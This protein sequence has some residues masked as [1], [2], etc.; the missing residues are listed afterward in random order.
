MKFVSLFVLCLAT[1]LLNNPSWGQ[2]GLEGQEHDSC[3]YQRDFCRLKCLPKSCIQDGINC[4]EGRQACVKYCAEQFL[5][6]DCKSDS[7]SIQKPGRCKKMVSNY[8]PGGKMDQNNL[9]ATCSSESDCLNLINDLILL[10]GASPVCLGSEN[11]KVSALEAATCALKDADH[12][13]KVQKAGCG[14]YICRTQEGFRGDK[15]FFL[16]SLIS[17]ENSEGLKKAQESAKKDFL[18]ICKA[19]LS[20]PDDLA[21][22]QAAASVSISCKYNFNIEGDGCLYEDEPA[23][24]TARPD[25]K[26]ASR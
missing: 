20:K 17:K 13:L 14:G 16:S 26:G 25:K 19:N 6:A 8:W 15:E 22:C 18:Q 21:S 1:T 23:Q 24:P 9:K 5:E 11:K 3:S 12:R 4:N 2:S 10:C 7:S